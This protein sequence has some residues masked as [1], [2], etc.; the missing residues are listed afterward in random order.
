MTKKQQQSNASDDTSL[1]SRPSKRA[2]PSVSSKKKR[3]KAHQLADTFNLEFLSNASALLASHA[4]IHPNKPVKLPIGA[5]YSHPFPHGVLHHVFDDAFLHAV[6][7]SML[8]QK[9]VPK[10][11]D[12]YH[13]AKFDE[14]ETTRVQPLAALRVALQALTP[15]ISKLTGEE[16]GPT[17]DISGHVYPPTGF[18]ACHDDDIGDAARGR[19]RVAFILYLVDADWDGP[20]DGG[21]LHLYETDG[22]EPSRVAKAL[23]PAWNSLVFFTV[24][25]AS[26]HEV[27]EVARR[28]RVSVS[29]WFHAP[30]TETGPAEREPDADGASIPAAFAAMTWWGWINA[31]Y[32]APMACE[33]IVGAF[34]DE[35]SLTLT[36]YLSDDVA[37]AVAAELNS[38]SFEPLGPPNRRK[39]SVLRPDGLKDGG[40]AASVYRALETPEFRRYVGLLTNLTVA[41]APHI[42][43]RRFQP[44]DYTLLVDG[45]DDDKAALD[46][47]LSF[48]YASDGTTIPHL[49]TDA[50]DDDDQDTDTDTART[51]MEVGGRL[52]YVDGDDTLISV[53]LRNNMLFMAYRLP[54]TKRF[55]RRISAKQTKQRIEFS[56]VYAVVE[57]A[58]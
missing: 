4:S 56:C 46:V 58:E 41:G 48:E 33:A 23:A 57:D 30:P 32:R 20:A 11:N 3:S 42:E 54:G 47:V 28:D 14:F 17:I 13:F 53:A 34:L 51:R 16:L 27:E 1:P 44:G 37:A 35:S 5:L 26:F 15:L 10:S 24:S 8:Q 39:Y 31:A 36:N 19:R 25:A 55:V 6:K 38:C 50:S 29:G 43:C 45:D 9:L 18:L 7:K 21:R 52:T 49:D 40:P 2:K 12:L 22:D